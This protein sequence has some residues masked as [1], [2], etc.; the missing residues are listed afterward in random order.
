MYMMSSLYWVILYIL[1][2]CSTVSGVP[3]EKRYTYKNNF[4]D[5]PL[6]V[7]QAQYLENS[8]LCKIEEEKKLKVTNLLIKLFLPSLT[9]GNYSL[10]NCVTAQ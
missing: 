8:Q 6:G 1:H 10:T 3:L 7:S 9:C 2:V 5:A 4:Q